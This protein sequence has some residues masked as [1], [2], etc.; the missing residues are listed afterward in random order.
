MTSKDDVRSARRG[1]R[2]TLGNTPHQQVAHQVKES[3]GG[4]VI[5]VRWNHLDTDVTTREQ[6]ISR[7]IT[8]S[9]EGKALKTK[10]LRADVA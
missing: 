1:A 9:G 5:P 7:D 4:R 8:A 3:K 10:I 2:Q 6:R